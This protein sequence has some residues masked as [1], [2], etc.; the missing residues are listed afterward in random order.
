VPAYLKNAVLGHSII[1]TPFLDVAKLPLSRAGLIER[2]HSS[3]GDV[4]LLPVILHNFGQVVHK[5]IIVG[6]RKIV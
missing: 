2:L 5:G 3:E 4:D 1:M 6:W